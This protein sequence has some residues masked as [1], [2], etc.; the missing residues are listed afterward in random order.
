LKRL[1]RESF[2][3]NKDQFPHAGEMLIML[4][5]GADEK[6]LADEMLTLAGRSKARLGTTYSPEKT[7]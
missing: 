3:R 7:S 2:R 5:R 4:R 1:L 6:T